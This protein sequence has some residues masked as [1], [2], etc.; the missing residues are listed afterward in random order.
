MVPDL[1][2]GGLYARPALGH[3]SSMTA[4][5]TQL[6]A[7]WRKGIEALE[8]KE[9]VFDRQIA[10]IEQLVPMIEVFNAVVPALHPALRPA[11]D[12]LKASAKGMHSPL[13]KLETRA[14][15]SAEDKAAISTFVLEQ[16]RCTHLFSTMNREIE[17]ANQDSGQP[18]KSTK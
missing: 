7:A 1:T 6:Y 14:P 4:N 5:N 9:T 12:R 11:L 13:K 17:L 10:L 16:R 8:E 15:L 2:L 3:H 18:A